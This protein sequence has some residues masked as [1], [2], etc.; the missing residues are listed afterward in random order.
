M[1][2]HLLNSANAFNVAK[3]FIWKTTVKI[4]HAI[5]IEKKISNNPTNA[6]IQDWVFKRSQK[7]MKANE[8]SASMASCCTILRIT[9]P[10][11]AVMK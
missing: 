3:Y 8:K 7:K 9:S 4:N 6:N 11:I 1:T 10:M 2:S 5:G